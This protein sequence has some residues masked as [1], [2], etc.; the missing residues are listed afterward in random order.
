M[1][2]SVIIPV[3]NGSRTIKATLDSV[4][5]Q[6]LPPD[7]IL[8]MDDGSTDDTFSILQSYAPR[9]TAFHQENKGVAAARNALCARAT[10]DLIAFLD[11][12]DVWHPRYLEHQ[13]HWSVEHPDAVGIFAGHVDFQGYGSYE[14][15]D[16]TLSP[17]I[18]IRTLDSLTFFT[19]LHEKSGSF[20]PSFLCVPKRVLAQI[21]E[22]PF[23]EHLCG[24]DDGYLCLRLALLGP[25]VFAPI[26][27]VAYRLHKGSISDNILKMCGLAIECFEYAEEHY[28]FK[29]KLYAAYNRAFAS[30]KR[31]YAKRLMG[32]GRTSEA[33]RHL[34]SSLSN[35]S[36]PASLTKSLGLLLL[37]YFPVALQPKWP[38]AQRSGG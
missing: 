15:K 14:W 20:F 10:G 36:H 29:G 33:R 19:S 4:L 2:I 35:S 3:Y 23:P 26:P 16:G 6:T 31:I 12:D 13:H 24:V 21:G 5:Q 18:E 7:E 11:S 28:R 17:A 32:V 38:P 37:S 22:K 27:L 25:V 9:V 30:V 34:F 1:R 8:V